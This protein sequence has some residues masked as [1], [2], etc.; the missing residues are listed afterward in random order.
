M[1]AL[2][3]NRIQISTDKKMV[4]NT[5]AMQKILEAQQE[6][7]LAMKTVSPLSFHFTYSTHVQY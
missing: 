1:L 5:Y 3:F 2:L 4:D 7:S 6:D